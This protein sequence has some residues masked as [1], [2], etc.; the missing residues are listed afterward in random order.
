MLLLLSY[1]FIGLTAGLCAGM[2]GVGGGIIIVPALLYLFKWQGITTTLAAHSATATS[3]ACMLLTTL[4]AAATHWRKNNVHFSL[5]KRYFGALMVGSIIGVLL[6]MQLSGYFIRH[7][8]GLFLLLIAWNLWNSRELLDDAPRQTAT[9]A[10]N[11]VFLFISML[12]AL[13]G[14]GGGVLMVP[15]LNR[16]GFRMVKAA[17]LASVSTLT[18]T[19]VGSATW[20]FMN[21][22]GFSNQQN[23]WGYI[24]W[25]A[26]IFVGLAAMFAAPWGI[27]IATH[28]KNKWLKRM[29]AGLVLAIAIDLLW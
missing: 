26:V 25:H 12:A 5:F 6:S 17:A 29:F 4:S 2:F 14:I 24:Q 27:K 11:S 13:L 22:F 21:H 19:L 20:I 23:S 15:Y 7:V 3:L 1:I 16:Q 9:W 18:I 28:L 10:L 8:F